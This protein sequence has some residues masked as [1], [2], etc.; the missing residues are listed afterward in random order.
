MLRL[1]FLL[2]FFGG[3]YRHKRAKLSFTLT[4]VEIRRSLC[5][6][7]EYIYAEHVSSQNRSR[8]TFFGA[9]PWFEPSGPHGDQAPRGAIALDFV[10]KKKEKKVPPRF[11]FYYQKYV[12]NC[13]AIF[14]Y[15]CGT[16]T[17]VQRLC[18]IMCCS[19]VAAVS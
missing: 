16:Y 14:F 10:Q 8:G 19:H 7:P 4:G 11:L 3:P 13:V 18:S 1:G 12:V 9:K 5:N 17:A 6:T 15:Y 2:L